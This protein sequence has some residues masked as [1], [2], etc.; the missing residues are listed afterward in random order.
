MVMPLWSHSP[1]GAPEV[2]TFLRVSERQGQASILFQGFWDKYWDF[3]PLRCPGKHPRLSVE[4]KGHTLRVNVTSCISH[5]H[6]V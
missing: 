3:G 2:C 1:T 6:G 4:T 5:S